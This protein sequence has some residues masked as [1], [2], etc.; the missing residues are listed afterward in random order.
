MANDSF[1]QAWDRDAVDR[2]LVELGHT[3]AVW[4]WR[5]GMDCWLSLCPVCHCY[6]FWTLDGAWYGATVALHCM[7]L[8]AMYTARR[9]LS[10]TAAWEE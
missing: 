5:S 8:A 4:Q 7:T 6:T 1:T 3:P 2:W 9:P 10:E